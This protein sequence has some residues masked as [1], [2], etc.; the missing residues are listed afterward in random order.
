MFFANG[1]LI[2]VKE[3]DLLNNLGQCNR[4]LDTAISYMFIVL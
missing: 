3:L 1:F 4:I 2:L